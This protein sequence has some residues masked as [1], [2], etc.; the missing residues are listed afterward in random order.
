MKRSGFSQIPII[1]GSQGEG[2]GQVLRSSLALSMVTGQPFRIE[3]IR[4][5]RPKPGLM[6][7]HLTGVR[8][9]VEVCGG[10]AEGDALRSTALSFT[11]GKV[12]AGDYRF[13]I[14]TAGS[15]TLVLQTVL[16]ALVLADGPSTVTLEGGTHN[17][18]APPFDF[19]AQTYL[20]LLN[21]MGPNVSAILE[22]P[23]FFP[24]GGGALRIEIEPAAKLSGFEL[25]ARGPIVRRRAVATVANLPREIAEREL[26]IVRLKLGWDEAACEVV[27]ARNTPGPGNL[28]TLEVESAGPDG[29]PGVCEVLTGFGEV[30]RK[31]EAVANQAVQ[32]CQ[33]Y[34]KSPASVGEYLAD[35]LLLPMAI[36]GGG[37]YLAQS[38]SRH[39]ETHVD[40]V[41]RFLDV[42]ID[43]KDRGRDGV[44]I[45]I[46]R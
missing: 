28:V 38:L 41:R 43:V 13:S 2:G 3:N 4:A 44:T 40:L 32:R 36:A 42:T 15:T 7:Q 37:A 12:R 5:G 39:T 25:M 21:R 11:P 14:G 1:D 29:G 17:P 33:R 34:L 22:R 27:D 9:A 46:D 8:A 20:P 35:Q 24:A 30:G 16:P 23:G 18:F 45:R 26:K 19:L 6:R 31:A 10:E